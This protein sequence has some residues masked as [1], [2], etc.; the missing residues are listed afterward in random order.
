[1]KLKE[2]C[3]KTMGFVVVA[4]AACGAPY[5]EQP[6]GEPMA[7]E[8]NELKTVLG[9]ALPQLQTLQPL[10]GRWACT[11]HSFNVPPIVVDHISVGELTIAWALNGF[12]LTGHYKEKKTAQ[13]PHPAQYEEGWSFDMGTQQFARTF[14]DN[15]GGKADYNSTS[16][17]HGTMAWSGSYRSL[18]GGMTV[19]VQDTMTLSPNKQAMSA[20]GQV[21]LGSGWVDQYELNCQKR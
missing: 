18:A 1:M 17:T 21:N 2:I 8:E 15:V 3:G 11:A 10:V 20:Q 7:A 4:L 12:W 13:N 5:E 14:I 16:V 6:S 9:P 19:L